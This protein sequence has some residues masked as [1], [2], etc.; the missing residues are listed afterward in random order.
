MKNRVALRRTV[1]WLLTTC[2]LAACHSDSTTAPVGAV[3]SPEQNFQVTMWRV[4][5]GEL[6]YV[7]PDGGM[8]SSPSAESKPLPPAAIQARKHE[9]E[10]GLIGAALAEA[11]EPR[12][13]A[14][15][16][17]SEALSL[18]GRFRPKLTGARR[19]ALG[20][21]K[22]KRVSL[23]LDQKENRS[24]RRTTMITEVDGRATEI[25]NF[26][27]GTGLRKNLLVS[28]TG[29]VLDSK[30]RIALV[31]D[32]RALP[33]QVGSASVSQRM[34]E[35]VGLA[36]AAIQQALLPTVAHAAPATADELCVEETEE[37]AV[38]EGGS[39]WGPAA[40]LALSVIAYQ[41]AAAAHLLA[42]SECVVAPPLTCPAVAVAFRN[43]TAA[44]GFVV[45]EGRELANC[46]AERCKKKADTS[47]TT[48]PNGGGG[49]GGGSGG[50]SP[51]EDC[52]EVVFEISYDD[53]LTWE[54]WRT[55]I[56]CN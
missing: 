14:P 33:A 25:R 15:N 35:L 18:G 4:Q 46:L 19:L 26:V 24:G 48:P 17:P 31:I 8:P 44:A 20:V 47:V 36:S 16:R 55:E 3:K 34:R 29:Y 7:S 42:V 9:L 45:A 6:H 27:F 1:A 38:A 10:N 50:P 43:M 51:A 5:G 54:Y 32:S 30:G 2:A 52:R 12:W 40:K 41:A 53:G 13:D 11:L 49:G 28:S 21:V 37:Q 22:G 56:I 23:Q 39:C